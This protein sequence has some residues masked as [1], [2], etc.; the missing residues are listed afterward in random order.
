[1]PKNP[2]HT[3]SRTA[4]VALTVALA[5]TVV[6]CGQKNETGAVSA[7]A[8]TSAI[9]P[10]PPPAAAPPPPTAAAVAWPPDAL[11]ELM[12]PV[13]LYPDIVLGQLLTAAT[14][15]QE[16]LDG[17]NWLLENQSLD[18][19]ALTLAAASAGFGPSMQALVHF[20]V[21]VD[22]MCQEIDWTTQVGDAVSADQQGVLD[23][24]QRLRLQ[25]FESGNL[26]STP[27]MAVEKTTQEG[28]DVVL[29]EPAQ[30]EVVYVPQYDPV[31]TYAAPAAAPTP[32]EP[33]ATATP[34]ATATEKSGISTTTAVIG[35]LLAF[36]G[37]ILVANLFDDDDDYYYPNY[38]RGG[39][40]YG[41]S[42]YYPGRYNYAPGYPGYRPSPYYRPP[43]NYRWNYNR[44]G[45]GNTVNV[46][47]VGNN[48]SGGNYFNRFENNQN[49]VPGYQP[50]PP[51]ARPTPLAAQSKQQAE[52][53]RQGLASAKRDTLDPATAQAARSKAAQVKPT[54]TY[55]GAKPAARP[56]GKPANLNQ[57][58]PKN[59][60][61]QAKPGTRPTAKPAQV[62]PAARPAAKPTQAKID[63][64]Y[65]KASGKRPDTSAGA[66]NKGG[67]AISGAGNAKDRAASQRGRA[68]TGGK[69]PA[70]SKKARKQQK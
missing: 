47:N 48:N 31:Q 13:A 37:G 58:V 55:A 35:G 1:M 29:L 38:G 16:V 30:P 67:T 17:G 18:G 33:L 62:K 50:R 60:V 32:I 4:A 63:R 42:P 53:R 3:R 45:G 54:G 11:D 36:G 14:N 57:Q 20:P 15:A 21:V 34:D 64:G 24:V 65:P 23:S 28:Q 10:P 40:Y 69:T 6:A 51:T 8:G 49:R 59:K 25:A 39:M 5:A 12:A 41:P 68:S 22:M 61:A 2:S 46:V 26:Q 27:Q 9:P 19:D 44:P 7:S 52:V 66:L 43:P 56:A 70:Q